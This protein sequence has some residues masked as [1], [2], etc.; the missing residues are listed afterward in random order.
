MK[1]ERALE[2]PIDCLAAIC[3][4]LEVP[5]LVALSRSSKAFHSYAR[6]CYD[7]L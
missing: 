1:L 6:A 5:D 3:Y 2:L 7:R 4:H